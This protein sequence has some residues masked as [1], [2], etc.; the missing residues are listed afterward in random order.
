MSDYH[1]LQ[2]TDAL[3]EITAVLHVPVPDENNA[4]GV[5][6]RTAV[7]QY[8]PKTESEV[9]WLAAEDPTEYAAILNGEIVERRLT[10]PVTA[11]LTLGQ[12]RDVMDARYTTF[13]ATVED[14][15]RNQLN[16]WGMDRDVPE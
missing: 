8:A 5:N 12:K 4:A 1:V 7:K 6:Y 15:I 2:T 11:T 10:I 13:A 14:Q 3:H 16:Y 9:P